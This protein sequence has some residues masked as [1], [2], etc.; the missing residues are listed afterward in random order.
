VSRVRAIPQTPG[1]WLEDIAARLRAHPWVNDARAAAAGEPRTDHVAGWF[2]A[3]VVPSVEGLRALRTSGERRL[4][5][6]FQSW[7]CAGGFDGMSLR[8]LRLVISLAADGADRDARVRRRHWMPIVE[9]LA[10]DGR[11]LNCVLQVPYDLPIFRGHFPGRPIVP[12]V[13]QA[14]WAATLAWDHGLADTPL[15]GI[16]AA[17]FNR[18]V[19]PG[20]RLRARIEQGPKPGQVQF[21]YTSRDA[22][23]A[24]GRLQFGVAR[25]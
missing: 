2:T 7:L 1:Q 11:G 3:S 24:T 16:P 12:G 14:G 22:V 6:E 17:K 9:D 4:A 10:R 15:S 8:D 18:I 25:D 13:M 20:M 19:R 21:R 5:D 23:V